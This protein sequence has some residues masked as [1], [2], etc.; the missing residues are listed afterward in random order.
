[1]TN[2]P[3]PKKISVFASLEMAVTF[4]SLTA[5]TVLIGAWCPQEAVVGREKVFEAFAP[6]VAKFL[7]KYGVSDIFHSPWFLFLIAML[8][9]NMVA[10]S[11]QRVFPKV[12][13]L[14]QV[15]PFLKGRQI[16]N[17]PVARKIYLGNYSS[18]AA[19]SF[20]VNE[21]AKRKFTVKVDEQ[22]L[23]AE[24]GK[25]GR[26][27]ATITHIGLLTLL[28]GVTVTS[29]TGYSGFQPVLLGETML[30]SG[31][32]HSKLWI[33]K[34]P[35]WGVRVDS[36]RRENYPSGEPKQW[37]SNLSIVD[38]KGKVLKQGE[39]SVNN[40]L[41]YDGTDIYQSSWG[42][43]AVEVSFN[44]HPQRMQVQ[45]MG[46]RYAAF[47]PLDQSTVFIFSVLDTTAP[48]RVFAKRPDW[49]APKL[50]S[51]LKPG[52]SV[53]LG[54]VKLKFDRVIPVSGLQYKNDPGLV[55]VY[56]AFAFIMVGVMLAAIPHR[57]IWVSVEQRSGKEDDPDRTLQL[58]AVE[59]PDAT[60][61]LN[62]VADPDAT[63]KLSA[64]E[65]PDVTLKLNATHEPTETPARIEA[66]H[67]PAGTYLYIG[68]KSLKAKTGFEKLID[69]LVESLSQQIGPQAP[70][71]VTAAKSEPK[72]FNDRLAETLENSPASHDEKLVAAGADAHSGD[73]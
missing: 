12:K 46:K 25:Y 8:T 9:L 71:A 50:I 13:L 11:F 60:L 18:S 26:L 43:D 49:E 53:T 44:G 1:M 3:T 59:D 68:G 34:L 51:E 73:S 36:T 48:M 72:S 41:S 42:I 16:E 31:S 67:E 39:I 28:A 57:H 5:I 62:N 24:S 2:D 61:K 63:L 20:V 10:V 65:D 58:G 4:M 52:E 70:P 22:S 56:I 40:P 47:L 21:L 33:G 27:A 55:T 14:K 45:P 32:Q 29:W 30:M 23:T 19:M 6:D 38:E 15:M 17:M 35:T 54:T 7:I 69:K 64:T 66:T 37:Y